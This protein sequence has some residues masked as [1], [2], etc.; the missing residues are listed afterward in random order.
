M[1]SAFLGIGLMV[2]AAAGVACV[3]MILSRFIVID[4]PNPV[5]ALP[6]ECGIESEGTNLVQVPVK[7]YLVCLLF[8]LFDVEVI[9][10]IT[11]ALAFQTM[12]WYATLAMAPFMAF[13]IVGL[14]YE[15]KRGA[16]KWQ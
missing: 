4:K 12:P 16:L 11:W 1:F 3:S 13:L 6:Y 5:K 7:F 15:W 10:L 9:F 2:A 14:V 8:L